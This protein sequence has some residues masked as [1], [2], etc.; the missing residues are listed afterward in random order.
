MKAA[1]VLI[2]WLTL[3][4]ASPT[5]VVSL[6]LCTDE[7]ALLL[8]TP[9][10]LASVTWLAADR[11]E[12]ALA[13]RA[14]R[15]HH[16]SGRMESVAPLAPDLILTGGAQNRYAAELARRLGARVLDI[17]P[18]QSL[19]DLR[20][21][22]RSVA[23]A[24]G[25][26][27]QGERLIAWMNTQ[28]GPIPRSSAPAILL[29]GGGYTPL[30]GSFAAD[31]LAHAGLRQQPFAG[32]RADLETLVTRPPQVIVTS[33]YRAQQTSLHQQWLRHPALA[34]LPNTT[35]HLTIDGRAWTCMGPLV[36]ADI[37]RLRREL[38]R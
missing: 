12:T 29:Q 11:H 13:P 1:I 9:G 18:P 5:R 27:T 10:Q 32:G 14:R 19:P 6:N 17:P 3:T 15:L 31:L 2:L 25:R 8:A 30:P 38:G 33:R 20:R 26:R 36:A 34:A 4:A 24:F 23:R 28:L 7:L 22:I 35:R 16:N 21:N 37:A